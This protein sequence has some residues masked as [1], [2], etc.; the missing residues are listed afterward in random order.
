MKCPDLRTSQG[1]AYIIETEA[2]YQTRTINK[3]KQTPT[4]VRPTFPLESASSGA[5]RAYAVKETMFSEYQHYVQQTLE[6]IDIMF[7]GSLAKPNG[8]LP[9]E[10]QPKKVMEM[11]EAQVADT[12]AS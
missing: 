12:V 3:R 8:H 6:I 11:V 10:L 1:Y 2:E 4:P 5:W 7:P 9:E